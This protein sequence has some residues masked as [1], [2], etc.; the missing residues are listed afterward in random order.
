MPTGRGDAAVEALLEKLRVGLTAREDAGRLVVE[1]TLSNG[2]AQAIHVFNVLWDYAPSGAVGAPDSP[3]YVCVESGELRLARRALPLPAG[4][5][6][7]VGIDPFLTEVAPGATLREEMSF[8]VPVQEYSCYFRRQDDSPVAPVEASTARFAYGVVLGATEGAFG[9]A[10]VPGAL[11]LVNTTKTKAIAAVE[12]GPVP[13][14]VQVLRRTD[15]F[16]RF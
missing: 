3:A 8:G 16:Q 1:A 6:V 10:P 15:A 7:I 4:R 5:K 14:T 12:S 13:C 2:T 11:R 9:P